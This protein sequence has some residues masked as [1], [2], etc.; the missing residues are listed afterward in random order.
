MQKSNLVVFNQQTVTLCH[1]NKTTLV[2]KLS[3]YLN[4]LTAGILLLIILGALPQGLY[5]MWKKNPS[6]PLA[7]FIYGLLLLSSSFVLMDRFIQ[8][9]RLN[10]WHK[11]LLFF[12]TNVSF[13]IGPF[14]FFFVK[15]QL[16]PQFKFQR[17]DIKHFILPITQ[18][19][20][21]ALIALTSAETKENLLSYFFSPATGNFERGV[22]AIHCTTYLYFAYRF[23]KHA[24]AKAEK[25]MTTQN[26]KSIT[27]AL[28]YQFLIVG[29]LKR[30]Y[31]VLITWFGIHAAFIVTDYFSYKLFDVNLQTKTLFSALYELSFA[32]FVAWLMLNGL[33]ILRRNL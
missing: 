3:F 21:L 12:P 19:I 24:R 1:Q 22:F 32:A 15:S 27:S 9:T 31:K 33:F 13:L 10:F 2:E 8:F 6:R 18:I 25:T 23:V 16:Y 7:H 29:W 26:T 28:R 14:V 11:E 20:V 5:F 4:Y 30:C 17:A